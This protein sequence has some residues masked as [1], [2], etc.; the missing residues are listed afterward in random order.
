MLINQAVVVAQC[1]FVCL[2]AFL[3]QDICNEL[4]YFI[5]I[6]ATSDAVSI[7]ISMRAPPAQRPSII[8]SRFLYICLS[9]Y[10][11]QPLPKFQFIIPEIG[12]AVLIEVTFPYFANFP[13]H[14]ICEC[15][16]RDDD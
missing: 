1:L 14:P 9:M 4:F 7:T 5:S 3:F 13:W 2:A 11:D 12:G 8:M 16:W 6:F 10:Q 15:L